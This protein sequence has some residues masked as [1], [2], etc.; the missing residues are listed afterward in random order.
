MTRKFAWTSFAAAA[1]ILLVAGCREE[2]VG[3]GNPVDAEA[4]LFAA[5]NTDDFAAAGDIV[6]MFYEIRD[7]DPENHRNTFLLGGASLWWLAEASHPGAN[8]LQITGQ[9]I[10]LILE[11]F[12]D[13]IQNDDEN[14]AGAQALLGAFLADG[15]FDRVAG[16]ALIEEA[17]A[18]KPVV[19]L[20]QRMHIRRFAFFD[21][22]ETEDAIDA[23]FDFWD[24]CAGTAID[25]NN[26]DY[27]AHVRPPTDAEDPRFCWGSDRVPHGYEGA[28]LIFGD[29]L[30]KSGRIAQAQRAY[31]N[32]TLG[33]NYDTWRYRP[34]VEQRLA[35]DLNARFATYASRYS[36]DWA[37]IGVP[38]RS[39]TQCHASVVAP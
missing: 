36:A 4:R 1:L 7:F 30:V 10:P 24:L 28:W 6:G 19:G 26:P 2:P 20:F 18:A 32:A 21:D 29:L 15:G 13:V 38:S 8:P 12:V 5:M 33:P 14:R 25:R 23:G 16:S 9:A 31:L 35:S 39:C 22:Q 34:E 11:S 17:V 37:P 27:T 3:P